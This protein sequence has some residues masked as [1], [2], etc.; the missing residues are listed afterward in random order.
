MPNYIELRAPYGAR[1]QPMHTDVG[2]AVRVEFGPGQE[3]AIAAWL[4]QIAFTL[5]QVAAIDLDP[6]EPVP[7]VVPAPQ[8]YAQPY[9]PTP[10]Q[11]AMKPLP[12]PPPAPAP[13]APVFGP[14]APLQ[15]ADLVSDDKRRFLKGDNG[16]APPVAPPRA[17]PVAN[18]QAPAPSVVRDP[19]SLAPSSPH[20]PIMGASSVTVE[21]PPAVDPTVAAAK[22]AASTL[23]N[24]TA[25]VIEVTAV[26]EGE[27]ETAQ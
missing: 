24:E 4:E 1:I 26:S 3:T 12:P 9:T 16:H 8:L 23:A 21:N 22:R 2:L 14:I 11:V 17:I 7:E 20:A 6:R 10:A 13:R 18:S 15:L 27:R 5:R 25:P 19:P